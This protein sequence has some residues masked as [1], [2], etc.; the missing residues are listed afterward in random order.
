MHAGVQGHAAPCAEGAPQR[1]PSPALAS[2]IWLQAEG[3]AARKALQEQVEAA[4]RK[5]KQMDPLL[6]AVAA[7]PWL[8]STRVRA[9]ACC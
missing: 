9:A 7:V 2:A 1:R 5:M 6:V 8:E 4:T 3:R